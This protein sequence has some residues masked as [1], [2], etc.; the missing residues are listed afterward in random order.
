MCPVHAKFTWTSTA[1]ND[2]PKMSHFN[3]LFK[4]KQAIKNYIKDHRLSG[5]IYTKNDQAQIFLK[6]LDDIT[7]KESIATWFEKVEYR[8]VDNIL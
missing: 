6:Y 4:Y 3:C 2:I 8:N 5:C 1:A 7:Y